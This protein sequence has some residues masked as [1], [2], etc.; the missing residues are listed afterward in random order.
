ML[1]RSFFCLCL[2][3][4]A[5][6]YAGVDAAEPLSAVEP[7]LQQAKARGLAKHPYWLALLHYRRGKQ[8]SEIVSRDFFLS[9]AG[10]S[11]AA[12]ELNATLAALYEPPGD[13]PDAHAQCRFIA[14]YKWLRKALD[15]GALEPPQVE[16]REYKAFAMNDQV[17]SLSLIYAT[18]YLSNPASFYGH[19][20]VK[21]NTR[22]P[23]A[24]T[25][26]LDQSINFGAVIPA[27]ENALVYVF[28][29]LFG[30]YAASFSHQRFYNF[31]HA[32]AENELRD[33]WE[34]V[35]TL[36]EDEVGQ[37]VAH[38]WELLGRK[39]VYFFLKQNCAYRMAEL[40]ELVIGQRLL[41]ELPWSLPG[42][43]FE[44]LSAL[45]RDGMPMVREVRRIPSRQHRFRDGFLAMTKAQ[46]SAARE[47]VD[48]GGLQFEGPGY[49]ALPEADR[50][51]VIDMLLD[52]YEYRIILDR[53][54]ISLRRAKQALLIERAGLPA[55]S[56]E[57]DVPASDAGPPHTG[58]LPF[59]VRLGA[60][61]NSRFGSGAALRI[62]PANYDQL[63]L[64]T[65]RIP[66]S[67]LAMFDL[68]AVYIEEELRLR[69]L[70][71]VSIEN[72][73]VAATPLPADGGLAWKFD[74][75]LASQNLECS[76]CTI[77]KVEGGV[78]KAMTATAHAVV[79]GMLDAF[80]QTEHANSGSLGIRPRLGMV[81]EP[82]KGWK[83]YITLARRSYL[84]GSRS[85]NGVVRWENR[86]GS[87]RNRDIRISYE[88]DVAHEFLAA[89]SFYW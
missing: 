3:L 65:G 31:N 16:C 69:S 13:T 26:L 1:S 78:G 87:R 29:G 24:A 25:H 44:Q 85:T 88:K 9:A 41:P 84:N 47:L 6:A 79:F 38:A 14:R 2:A 57:G 23:T 55:Q 45:K 66:H 39:Y 11:D 67:K 74:A 18:G 32:Y 54:D 53:K 60:L 34:Y 37:I 49:T 56:G 86:F 7:L 64:D 19:I 58:S 52:Y 36:S 22:Q 20:L 35:L 73:N 28:K 83:S 51:A 33:M 40:L 4:G 89:L 70:E 61:R 10:A 50:I 82:A 71:L 68:H 30:G 46:Q 43:M 17:E 15:W 81:A 27:D 62:R 76:D 80:A 12:A 75:G 72:L 63:A 59:M 77:F 48:G 5:C 21:F 8:G 42:A